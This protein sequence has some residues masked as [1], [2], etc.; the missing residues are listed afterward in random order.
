[1]GILI[2]LLFILYTDEEMVYQMTIKIKNSIISPILILILC[3]LVAIYLWVMFIIRRSET[4]QYDS[5]IYWS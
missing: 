5:N 4:S 1:M 2:T 3:I